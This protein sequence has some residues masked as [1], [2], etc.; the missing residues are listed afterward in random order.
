M[1]LTLDQTM[2]IYRRAIDSRAE[3]RGDALD[4]SR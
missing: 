3:A 2:L 4:Q 1:Q